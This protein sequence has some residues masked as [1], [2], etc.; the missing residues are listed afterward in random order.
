LHYGGAVFFTALAVVLRLLVDA[1]L[2]KVMPFSTLYGAVALAVWF[3]GY[4]PAILAAAAG[5]LVCAWL[6]A[7]PRGAFGFNSSPTSSGCASTS[8]PAASSSAL[9]RRCT[10]SAEVPINNGSRCGS[11]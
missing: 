4:R 11:R 10:P 3:G 7:E 9:G 5:Y 1:W 2:G 6:F 8:S